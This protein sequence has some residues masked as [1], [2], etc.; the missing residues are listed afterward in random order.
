MNLPDI[1]AEAGIGAVRRHGWLPVFV[2]AVDLIGFFLHF[3]SKCTR[4]GAISAFSIENHR[5]RGKNRPCSARRTQRSCSHPDRGGPQMSVS[6]S[7]RSLVKVER[8]R[9]AT[10]ESRRRADAE[11]TIEAQK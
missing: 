6:R 10:V 3:L 9:R 8:G 1:R 7:E 5:K 4:K 2:S 11:Q